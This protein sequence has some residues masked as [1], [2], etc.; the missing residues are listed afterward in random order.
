MREQLNWFEER[1]LYGKKMVV[2][3]TRTQAGELSVRLR[4][5]GADVD[6]MPT[7]R[8]EPPEDLKGFGQL[9]QDSHKYDWIVFTSPNGVD[10][11]FDIF[12]KLYNDG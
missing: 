11:F 10:A 7:I 5:L 9:V 2:T 12:F 6:E 8:I 1:S 4:H 3:R